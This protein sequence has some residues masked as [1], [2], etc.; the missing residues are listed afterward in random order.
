METDRHS[1]SPDVTRNQE[2]GENEITREVK[3][4]CQRSREDP[5]AVL[6]EMLA[7]A[8][9]D[10]DQIQIDKIKEAQ[11]F[12]GCRNIRKRKSSS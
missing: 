10:G 1:E 12:L 7:Q 4:R 3:K 8:Q 9:E 6:R 2:K 11:K 5:C